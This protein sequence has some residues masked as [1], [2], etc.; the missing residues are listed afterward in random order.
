MSRTPEAVDAELRAL[1]RRGWIW[2]IAGCAP[3]FAIIVAVSVGNAI[4]PG[5]K[6]DFNRIFWGLIPV[7][8]IL[9]LTIVM[10]VPI[11][12][13]KSRLLWEHEQSRSA[14]AVRAD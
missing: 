9:V 3:T 14:P 13:R 7:A 1:N 5:D 6:T 2:A 4:I 10:V 11:Q 8:L 12:K